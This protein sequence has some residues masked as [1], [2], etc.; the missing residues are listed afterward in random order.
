MEGNGDDVLLSELQGALATLDPVPGHVVAAAKACLTWRH[1]DAELAELVADTAIQPADA[2]RTGS[3]ESG[4]ATAPRLLTFEAPGLT[5]EVEVT[6]QGRQRRLQGQ[7]VPP[8][9]AEIEVRWQG[10]S[11]SSQANSTGLFAAGPV[12]AGPVSIACDRHGGA[13][14]VVTSWLTI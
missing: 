5:V 14:P 2:A 9:S 3:Q 1:V 4:N 10:G 11:I 7:L 13:G 8:G 12:P 6:E